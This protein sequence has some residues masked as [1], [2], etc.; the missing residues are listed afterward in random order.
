MAK[1]PWVFFG[2]ERLRNKSE[3]RKAKQELKRGKEPQ[4]K[5]RTGKFWTD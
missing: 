2:S 1:I 5:Y 4:P 3:R